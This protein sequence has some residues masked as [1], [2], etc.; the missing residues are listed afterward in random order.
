MLIEIKYICTEVTNL[1]IAICDDEIKCIAEVE[2]CISKFRENYN[3]SYDIFNSG[4]EILEV[5]KKEKYKYD[6][7]IMDIELKQI[8]GVETANRI[9]EIDKTVTIF[10]LT[11]HTKY[12]IDCFKC[13][14]KNFWVKPIDYNIFADDMEVAYKYA[15][16]MNVYF[17]FKTR[18]EI[19]KLEYKKILYFE[20]DNKKIKIYTFDRM[21]E[22][23]GALKKY[24]SVIE[25]ESFCSPH[26]SFYVNLNYIE[27]IRNDEIL[28]TGNITIP[29]S[30]SRKKSFR[31]TFINFVNRRI[32]E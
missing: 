9:R 24:A 18:D 1:R 14:P 32:E 10:F 31:N 6:V 2:N 22:F 19:I 13:S 21:Y 4:E 20:S 7:V 27:T 23:S 26:K 25:K 8:N 12:A 17:S 28:L 11:N 29:V 3:V 15:K 30:K 5:Y 16:K